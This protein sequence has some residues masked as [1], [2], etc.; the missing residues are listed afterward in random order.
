MASTSS[1]TAQVQNRQISLD[2]PSTDGDVRLF[3]TEAKPPQGTPVKAAMLLIHGFPETSHQFRHVISPL[4]TTEFYTKR[5]LATDLHDLVTKHLGI[6]EPIHVVGHDIG[7]MIAHAYVAQYP[8]V[9]ASTIWG[10]CPLPGSSSYEA[11]KHSTGLWHFDFQGHRPELAAALV[12]GK[13]RL[14]L[15]DFYDRLTQNQAAWTPD[16]VD[17]YVMQYSQPDALRCAFLSY[18]A[19]EKDAADNREWREKDGKVKVKNLVLIGESCFMGEEDA[20]KRGRELYDDVKVASVAGAGHYI[21]EENP[22]DFV[23][24]VLTFVEG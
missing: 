7:G 14:Y 24:Q 8:D 9:V 17:F 13:E 19:F 15:K 18:R 3:F 22:E 12:A 10:E 4:S 2:K 23:K 21:A 1:T 16:V 20:E 6:K 5:V 11:N